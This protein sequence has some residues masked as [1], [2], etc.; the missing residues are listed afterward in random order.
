MNKYH[1]W[2][3]L[4]LTLFTFFMSGLVSRAVFEHLPHLEDEVAYLFQARLLARGQVV[5]DSPQLSRPFWQPFVLDF[6]GKRFGKYPLG[7]PGMLATGVLMGQ[8]WVVNALLAATTVALTYRLGREIFNP[9]TG[10]IAAALVSFSPMALLLNGT[11]MS[12]T[13]ALFTT[14]LFLYAYWRMERNHPRPPPPLHGEGESVAP[15]NSLSTKRGLRTKLLWGVLAGL[16]LGLTIIN[17]PVAGLALALP[18]VVWSGVRMTRGYRLSAVIHNLQPLIALALITGLICTVVP[19]YNFAATGNP[20]QNLYLLV[21]EYDQL[22]FGPGYGRNVHTLEKGLRQTRWDLSL[23]AADLFGWQTGN[24]TPELQQHLKTAGDYWPN[25]GLSWLL[26]PF[27]LLIGFKGRWWLWAIW[28]I[29][30]IVL[31]MLSTN[32]P[33]ETLRDPNFANLW[34]LGAFIWLCA[35]FMLLLITRYQHQMNWTFLLLTI[36]LMLIGLHVAYWIGSQRY[37]TR[38]YYEA[39][40]SFAIISAI[41]L[42]WLIRRFTTKWVIYAA[43]T[44]VCLYS[45]YAY[46]TPRINALYRFNWVSPELI[47][48][49]LDRRVDDR[50]VLVL[51]SGTD[52]RWRAYGSLMVSTSPFLDSPIVAAWDSGDLRETLL[53][54]F[55]DRQV[56]EMTAQ[57]NWA[58]FVDGACFGEPP[59]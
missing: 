4:A 48:A 51:V 40:T 45:L 7:W 49:V 52:V 44:G 10:V 34:L 37:S 15:E 29:I 1:H 54:R 50:P 24:I 25:V 32:L 3:A 55:P 43:L 28:F 36:P 20:R 9:D 2:L 33:V 41:P 30:G 59:G 58:C 42:A 6:S 39:L 31:F 53:E 56:I 14:T 8:T 19:L 18:F 21:W 5:I 11:L 13:A 46:S 26:L 17:R 47:E 23:T 35:P 22:G 38:Y 57:G 12:H 16:A 27:G